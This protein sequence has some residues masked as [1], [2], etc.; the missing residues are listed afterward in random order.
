MCYEHAV[1][2][3]E[4]C[5]KLVCYDSSYS[6][7]AQHTQCSMYQ[8]GGG[9]MYQEGGGWSESCWC[10]MNMQCAMQKHAES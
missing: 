1:C 8:E 4:T 9:C 2:Y 5:R 10:A 7:R 3:A 6:C